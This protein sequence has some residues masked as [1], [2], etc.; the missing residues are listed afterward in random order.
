[1][2][3]NELMTKID[4]AAMRRMKNDDEWCGDEYD[5]LGCKEAND[6]QLRYE[7]DK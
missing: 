3:N 6:D 4:W 2:M 7:L 1:M 5:R